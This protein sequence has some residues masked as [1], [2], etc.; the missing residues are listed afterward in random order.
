MKLF[1][2]LIVVLVVALSG[3]SAYCYKNPQVLPESW[4]FWVEPADTT[5]GGDTPL[6]NVTALGRLEPESEIVDIGA[7]PGSVINRFPQSIRQGAFVE[8]DDCLAYLDSHDEMEAARDHAKAML[9]E[10]KKRYK[11]ET[12]FGDA[13]V[14]EAKLRIVQAD[15]VAL[16]GIEAQAAEVR[17][18]EA[19]LEKIKKDVARDE[20]LLR[21]G[22]ITRDKYDITVL[23]QRQSEEQLARNKAMR[24]QL[25]QDRDIKLK[26]AQAELRS[27]EAGLAKAQLST[28]LDALEK[29]KELAERRLQR[30]IIYAPIA[31]EIIRIYT[32]AG[33]TVSSKPIL[34]MGSTSQMVAV[35]EVYETD[36]RHVKP[37]QRARVTS[38]SFPDKVLTGRVVRINKLIQKNDLLHIDP[39]AD[40]DARVVEV[41]IRLDDSALAARYNNLQ[42]DVHISLTE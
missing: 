11:A 31:G 1:K 2:L 9:E 13:A 24:A 25:E 28:Q 4:R 42:V 34:K 8:K 5:P 32:R 21:D 37:G 14:A 20:K 16:L 35:A 30:S 19:E 33:E 17:R 3:A 7:T 38:K 6:T 10:A 36:V 27:A 39:T 18:C 29:A 15:K 23:T 26:L 12:E 40:A 22:A 41:R